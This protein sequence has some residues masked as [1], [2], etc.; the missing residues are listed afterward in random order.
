MI[1]RVPDDKPEP[2]KGWTRGRAHHQDLRERL[3]Q[4]ADAGASVTGVATVLQVSISHVSK[5]LGRRRR[6]GETTARPQRGHVPA[7][8]AAYHDAIRARISAVPDA[9]LTELR[10]W[11]KETHQVVASTTLIWEALRELK[12]TLKKD[13]ACCGADPARCCSGTNRMARGASDIEPS[14]V[15]IPR[16]NR[17]QDEYALWNALGH[18]APCISA[19]ECR[20]FSV[21]P[22]ISSQDEN[23]LALCYQSGTR[24]VSP[25]MARPRRGRSNLG[26]AGGPAPVRNSNAIASSRH[27]SRAGLTMTLSVR[28]AMTPFAQLATTLFAQ[29]ATTLFAQLAVPRFVRQPRRVTD[30]SHDPFSGSGHRAMRT[31]AR[32]PAAV[33]RPARSASARCPSHLRP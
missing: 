9:T 25:V 13:R 27:A 2:T 14:K 18:I 3:F 5:V 28:P 22:D 31:R 1:L 20:N 6:T 8:L 24:H 19:E 26:H 12:L 21:T 11:L 10:V 7:K 23:A 17:D 15:G 16:R 29:L 4:V 32:R 30:R 33:T